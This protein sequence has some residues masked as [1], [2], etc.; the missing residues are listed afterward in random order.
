MSYEI[1][2]DGAEL[3]YTAVHGEAGF[4]E[5]DTVL[6]AHVARLLGHIGASADDPLFLVGQLYDAVT[7]TIRGE[8][9][10]RVLE[11]EKGLVGA[12]GRAHGVPTKKAYETSTSTA[13]MPLRVI[14]TADSRFGVGVVDDRL[15]VAGEVRASVDDVVAF[16]TGLLR[17]DHEL[18]RQLGDG[19]DVDFRRW[20]HLGNEF[21]GLGIGRVE[22]DGDTTQVTPPNMPGDQR[23][24]ERLAA[25]EGE[26]RAAAAVVGADPDLLMSYEH[27]E[28]HLETVG[29]THYVRF[30]PPDRQRAI[31][32]A[33]RRVVPRTVRF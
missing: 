1:T 26:L 27:A 29:H 13:D 10:W 4:E 17:T 20:T 23:K 15:V 31:A 6:R 24:P 19:M 12:D 8:S 33:L 30:L 21:G 16:L 5:I 14:E 7:F 18:R 11:G 28:R 22:I 32:E 3:T 2:F 9:P 25:A